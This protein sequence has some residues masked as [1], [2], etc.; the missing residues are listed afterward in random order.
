MS[1][2]HSIIIKQNEFF[3]IPKTQEG[4]ATPRYLRR[5]GNESQIVH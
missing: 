5:G 2:G 3:S 4:A 1:G